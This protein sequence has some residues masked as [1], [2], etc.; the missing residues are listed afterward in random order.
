MK[1]CEN[2][3]EEIQIHIGSGRFCSI[4]CARSFASK[5][6]KEEK[7]KKISKSLSGKLRGKLEKK[8]ISVC[9]KCNKE[10]QSSMPFA[11]HCPDYPSCCVNKIEIN[12]VQQKEFTEKQI[13]SNKKEVKI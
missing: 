10:F 12:V 2:C 11:K 7:N 1:N 8:L 6:C 5:N 3:N 13:A 9:K 4:K